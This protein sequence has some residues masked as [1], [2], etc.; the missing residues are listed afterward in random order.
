ME[1]N[2]QCYKIC[3]PGTHNSTNIPY[4]CEKDLFCEKYYNYTQ[5]GC[6]EYIPDGFYLNSTKTID[7]C[8]N[9]CNTCTRESILLYDR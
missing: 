9:K 4:F 6:L 8:I 1:Y 3:P 2:N 5:T 7:K